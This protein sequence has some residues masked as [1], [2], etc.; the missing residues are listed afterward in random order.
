MG[1]GHERRCVERLLR[2]RFV[3]L[4][5]QFLVLRQFLLSRGRVTALGQFSRS[6]ERT[7][8]AGSVNHA[9]AA[10]PSPPTRT[11]PFSSWSKPA[12]LHSPGVSRRGLTL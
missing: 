12:A 5:E 1:S 2:Q 10:G 3:V 4:R 7:F 6:T 11:M 9:I 8:P